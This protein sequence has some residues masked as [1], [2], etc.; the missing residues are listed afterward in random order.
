[1]ERGEIFNSLKSFFSL[2]RIEITTAKLMDIACL[3]FVD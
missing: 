2:L 3:L 1:M